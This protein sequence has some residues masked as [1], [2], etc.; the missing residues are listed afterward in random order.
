MGADRSN[1]RQRPCLVRY[2]A[3]Q[4]GTKAGAPASSLLLAEIKFPIINT[5]SFIESHVRTSPYYP[6]SNGKIERWHGSLK[7]EFIRPNVP[8]SLEEA[9]QLVERYV[10][11]YNHRR[12]HSA[13][14]YVT[15]ADK[16]AGRAQAIFDQRDRKL[17]EARARRAQ[18]RQRQRED[19]TAA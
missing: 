2:L 4:R 16:L 11:D 9:R 18:S 6:Q 8:L 7:R 1:S 5:A 17:T 15:P 12:L 10:D 13:I 3:P 14:G 19:A